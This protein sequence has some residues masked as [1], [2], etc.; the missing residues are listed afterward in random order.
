[1]ANYLKIKT[2]ITNI[3][4]SYKTLTIYLFYYNIFKFTVSENVYIYIYVR[5]LKV[6]QPEFWKCWEVLFLLFE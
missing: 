1:M 2:N 4:I 6:M 3:K 5:E